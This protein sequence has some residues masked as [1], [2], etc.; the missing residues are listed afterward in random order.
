M[1]QWYDGMKRLID[2]YTSMTEDG[3]MPGESY[4]RLSDWGQESSGL[5]NKTLPEFTITCTYHYLLKVMAEMA[6]ET[7]HEADSQS[8][9]QLARTNNWS[10]G[11]EEWNC[12]AHHVRTHECTVSIVVLEE[13]DEGSSNRC[14]LLWSNIDE[15]NL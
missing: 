14:N 10:F 9:E 8:F 2:Y 3:L 13:W 5:K 7:G 15:V 1:E 11:T 12:L 6:Q 4:S